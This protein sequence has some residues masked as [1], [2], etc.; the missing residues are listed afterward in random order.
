LRLKLRVKVELQPRTGYEADQTRRISKT[1]DEKQRP[2]A[3]LTQTKLAALF[4]LPLLAAAVFSVVTL[5]FFTLLSP[6]L[7]LTLPALDLDPP[8]GVP[9]FRYVPPSSLETASRSGGGDWE[10]SREWKPPELDE[11]EELEIWRW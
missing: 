3:P 9:T 8:A 2:D 6:P 10:R 1:S 4:L 5:A 7:L 11:D